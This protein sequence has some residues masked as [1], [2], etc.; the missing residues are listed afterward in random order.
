M[1]SILVVDD[2][3]DHLGLLSHL[4]AGEGISAIF[5]PSG[6]E[7]IL[8]LQG[9]H[10]ITLLIT[11]LHMP[12]MDGIELA[13]L[14]KEMTPDITVVLMTGAISPD[15]PQFAAEAGITKIIAKPFS[16]GQFLAIVRSK[17]YFSR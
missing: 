12:G 10:S 17:K 13:M 7:A 11:D 1:N 9:D 15:V 6:E 5:V 14:A 3:R 2:D 16:P 8:K 4:V